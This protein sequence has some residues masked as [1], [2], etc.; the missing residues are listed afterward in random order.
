MGTQ[1][2]TKSPLQKW[3]FGNTGKKIIK[4]TYQNFLVLSTFAWY[5][6]LFAKYFGQGCLYK[7]HFAYNLSVAFQLQYLDIVHNFETFLKQPFSSNLSHA[8][9]PS[10]FPTSFKFNS[11]QGIIWNQRAASGRTKKGHLEL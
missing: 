8:N 6:L 7:K 2:W 1:P 10:K 3:V 5:F 11:V 9:I 4:K